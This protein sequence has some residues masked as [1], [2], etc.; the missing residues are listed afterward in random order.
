MYSISSPSYLGLH[1]QVHVRLNIRIKN[2]GDRWDITGLHYSVIK[3]S[4]GT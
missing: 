4:Q 1:E 2:S 3:L